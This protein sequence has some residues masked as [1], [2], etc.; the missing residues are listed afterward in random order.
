MKEERKNLRYDSPTKSSL[1]VKQTNVLT[2]N[3]LDSMLFKLKKYKNELEI[4]ESEKI[5][6]LSFN[7][8]KIEKLDKDLKEI[9][10]LQDIELENERVSV[11]N[12]TTFKESKLEIE[13]K[14]NSLI[15][16]LKISNDKYKNE[17]DYTNTLNFMILT[18]KETLD[19]INENLV[20]VSEQKQAVKY[21]L[22]NLENNQN[23][24]KK[25]LK[26]FEIVKESL[27][28]E[29]EKL[30][31]MLV[32]QDKKL[33]EVTK[34]LQIQKNEIQNLQKTSLETEKFWEAKY[35]GEK[36]EILQK[37]KDLES[38]K[39]S[40]LNQENY[41]IKLI[42]GLDIISRYFVNLD[43]ENKE[44]NVQ[45]LF[46]S[47]D[48]KTF[49]ANKYNI[50]QDE[51]NILYT[52]TNHFTNSTKHLLTNSSNNN[53][54][55]FKESGT[56][57]EINL[58][59]NYNFE[60][61]I[62]IKDLKFKFDNLEID[63]SSYFNLLAKLINKTAFYHTQMMNFNQKQ[64]HLTSKKDINT[65]KVKEI[66]KKNYKNFESLIVLN[67]K[68]NDFIKKNSYIANF[69]SNRESNK[70]KEKGEK[71]ILL[72]T[73]LIFNEFYKKCNNLISDLKVYFE[74][75]YF[76]F[77]NLIPLISDSKTKELS[78][79]IIKTLKNTFLKKNLNNELHDN[80]T[81]LNALFNFIKVSVNPE[82]ENNNENLNKERKDKINSFLKSE[83]FLVNN[84]LNIFSSPDITLQTFLFA[85][86][87]NEEIYIHIIK[88]IHSLLNRLKQSSKSASL[89]ITTNEGKFLK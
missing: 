42:L 50:Y 75:I 7:K 40:K 18:E 30:D 14:I 43:K 51:T 86:F 16:K 85:W 41:L 47:E 71:L 35:K 33:D 88:D 73:P 56:V 76:N 64:I 1:I 4:I 58:N 10:N 83:N 5:K 87:S 27:S 45:D 49:T 52:Y 21:S 57:N 13:E 80:L 23:E 54:Y 79:K 37:I 20:I 24:N 63:F 89:K 78:R 34:N 19:K 38:K 11:K 6:N 8:E 81:Y 55:N 84:M 62:L 72:E 53:N 25:K 77:K 74:F 29:H 17:L 65:L 36:T 70:L 61:K 3:D 9:A 12:K 67:S 60:T 26:N 68:F 15:E 46:L 48:Y 69:N 31:Q 28:N 39:V 22:K 59:D 82:N 44:I 66:L 32:L 2:K